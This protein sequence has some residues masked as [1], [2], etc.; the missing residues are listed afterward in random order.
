ME[1]WHTLEHQ[2]GARRKDPCIVHY[3]DSAVIQ[4][5]CVEAER[6]AG[7]LVRSKQAGPRR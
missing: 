5:S 4:S 7:P 3:L 6:W 2:N 1:N